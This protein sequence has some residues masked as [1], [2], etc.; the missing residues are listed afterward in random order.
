MM[1]TVNQGMS[2]EEIERVVAQRVA[3]AIEAIAIYET[4]TNMARKSTIQTERQED[5]VTENASNKRKWEGNHNGSSSQQNKGH[6][7]PRAHTTWPINKKAY[8]GSL[9]LCNQCKFHHNGPCTVKCGN[10]KKFGHI[11]RNCRTPTAARNQRTLT[12]YE[13]GSLGHYKSNCPTV[14]FQ[15]R[16][17]MY[18]KGKDYEDSS[19]TTSNINT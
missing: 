8:A 12:C 3:N 14:R 7:V 5:K 11:T 9:P 16:V 19:A 6:K 1:T 15:N 10:C 2:I 4:K 13:C 17:D 18:W